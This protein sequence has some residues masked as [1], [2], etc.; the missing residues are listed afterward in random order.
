MVNK[1]NERAL[2]L[3]VVLIGLALT[4]GL[5]LRAAGMPRKLAHFFLRRTLLKLTIW[6]INCC[7]AA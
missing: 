1:V 5:F 3:F 4:V 7:G 6:C 2:R